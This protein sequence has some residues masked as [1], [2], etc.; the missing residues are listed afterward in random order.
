[1]AET[2][3]FYCAEA[4]STDRRTGGGL[5]YQRKAEMLQ[6]WLRP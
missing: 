4:G 2:V 1:M 5:E 3:D 6:I